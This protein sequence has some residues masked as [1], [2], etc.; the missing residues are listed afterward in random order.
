[1]T[2]HATIHNRDFSAQPIRP[3]NFRIDKLTWSIYGG[4][5]EAFLSAGSTTERLLEYSSLLRCPITISEEFSIPAWWGYINKISFYF[6]KINFIIDLED[7]YNRVNVKYSFLSPDGKLSEYLETGFSEDAFSKSEF[8][9][10]EIVLK[11]SNIDDDF[12][13]NLRNTFLDLSAFPRTA[14]S[15]SS[16]LGD[17]IIKLHCKGWFHTL[18]WVSYENLDGFYANHG[19]GP[20]AVASGD[21]TIASIAQ[22]FTPAA[23]TSI[24]HAYFLMRKVGSPT[25][26]IWCRLYSDSGDAPN[27]ILATTG[28]VLGSTLPAYNYT[29]I[30]FTFAT[31][32]TLTAATK[33]WIVFYPATSSSTN[34]YQLR[35]DENSNFSQANHY[36]RQYSSSAWNLI[37][38]VTNPGSRPDLYFRVVCERDTGAQLFDIATASNQFFTFIGNITSGVKTSP[39][40]DYGFSGLKEVLSLMKLGTSNQRLITSSVNSQRRLYWYEQPDPNVPTV[41]LDRYGRFFSLDQKLIQ[42]YFPPIG[43]FATVSGIDRLTMPF[44]RHRIPTYFVDQATYTP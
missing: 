15:P 1:M 35:V 32:Y 37:T 23:S 16:K 10:R 19:P 39:Y 36:A 12:A 29:W 27:A 20:G 38:S 24:K 2:L 25:N 4:P 43:Q 17:P 41:Y 5:D 30:K 44:D 34:H 9:T 33:Y 31:S 42:P 28:S 14:L 11:Q 22:S 21:S 3:I 40:R 18:D 6:E 7:L 8:G 13:L 26:T